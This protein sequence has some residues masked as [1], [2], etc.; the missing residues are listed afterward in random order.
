MVTAAPDL[1]VFLPGNYTKSVI[2]G[3]FT[4]PKGHPFQPYNQINSISSTR[5]CKKRQLFLAGFVLFRPVFLHIPITPECSCH[6]M[7]LEPHTAGIDLSS[8]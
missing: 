1:I 4:L 6:E 5:E 7:L 3:G 2:T 8:H